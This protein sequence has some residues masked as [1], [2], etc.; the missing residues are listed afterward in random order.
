MSTPAWVRRLFHIHSPALLMTG[1]DP[2]TS[3]RWRTRC[4]FCRAAYA[5]PMTQEQT[6]DAIRRIGERQRQIWAWLEDDDHTGR[7]S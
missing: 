6:W 4:S 2:V 5:P 1:T 7:A 3:R